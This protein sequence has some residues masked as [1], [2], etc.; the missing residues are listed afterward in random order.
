M[1]YT[2]DVFELWEAISCCAILGRP[3]SVFKL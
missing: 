3:A 1:L 2:T